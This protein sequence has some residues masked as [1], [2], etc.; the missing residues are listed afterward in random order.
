MR[1]ERTYVRVHDGIEDHPKVAPLSDKAF[2][3]LVTTWG[4]C[5]RHLT[6]GRVPIAVWRQR[7][8][9]KARRELVAAELVELHD[10]HVVMHDYLDHQRSADEVEEKR[11]A[12][13]RAGS[14][15]NHRRWHR[16]K[17]DPDCPHCIAELSQPRSQTG[18]RVRSVDNST[19]DA[20][21]EQDS[22][23]GDEKSTGSNRHADGK[24]TKPQ[25][26]ETNPDQSQEG[27]QTRSRTSRKTSPETETEVEKKGVTWGGGVTL[28]NASDSR[29]PDHCDQHRDIDQ[30]PPCRA[31][32]DAR[33][34][35]E[36]W[37]TEQRR[38]DAE[39]T[40]H[41]AR[42]R[43][44]LR[45]QAIAACQQCDDTGY[46]GRQ[47]CDHDPTA[48]DRAQRGLAAVHAALRKDTT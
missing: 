47:L 14:L 17:S 4:W 39:R 8:T 30:P 34:S 48:S 11:E 37:D 7:G 40:S 2:R 18:S 44:E 32:A 38:L 6:D 43:A 29:P 10:D 9:A 24:A 19:L 26:A 15:G 36:R 31:C 28:A 12:K 1:D 42:E 27:S 33:R 20:E 22:V 35:A 3:L 5:S 25:P 41:Q 46:I 13:R 45:T 23:G 16:D 21:S